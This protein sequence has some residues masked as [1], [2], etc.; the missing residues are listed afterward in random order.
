[1]AAL[2]AGAAV[3]A[4]HVST[5]I[6]PEH[7]APVQRESAIVADPVVPLQVIEPHSAQALELV[8]STVGFDLKQI[9]RGDGLV[10]AVHL[11]SLPDDLGAIDQVTRKKE[12][13]FS[14]V[15]PLVLSANERVIR[16]R[17]KLVR[18]RDRVLDGAALRAA[19]RAWLLGLADRYGVGAAPDVVL[20]RA[21]FE[22]VIDRVDTVPV[23]LALA[24]AA[25]ESGWGASRFARYGNALFGQRAWSDDKGIVPTERGAEESHVVRSFDSLLS[26]VRS[27]IHNLN[28]HP[29]YRDFREQRAA[30]RAAGQPLDAAGL[31]G[32]LLSYAET[33][34][35]YVEMLRLVM[36]VNS[37]SDFDAALLQRNILTAWN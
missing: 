35:E 7:P 3:I 10:P 15:L 30:M 1:M 8:L 24:Q 14:A 4:T 2:V 5:F 17:V 36:K 27:Y 26:S 21:F 12:L 29:S 13:F 31:A 28:T 22:A 23:S 19:E 6:E 16:D 9:R 18:F 20:D 34:E 32:E 11:A 25:V 33:G 37:L